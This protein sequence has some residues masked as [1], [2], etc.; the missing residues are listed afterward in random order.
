MK[1]GSRGPRGRLRQIFKAR[2]FDWG[3]LP[4]LDGASILDFFGKD[5]GRGGVGGEP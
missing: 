5:P 2:D 1:L 3:R 4:E